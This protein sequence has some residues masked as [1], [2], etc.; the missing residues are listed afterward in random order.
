VTALLATASTAQAHRLDA[1]AFLLPGNKLQVEGWFSSGEPA[2]G[3][4]V[5]IHGAEDHLLCEGKL[6]DQ[7]IFVCTL[8][9]PESLHIVVTAGD[10][11]RKELYVSV[12]DGTVQASQP[13]TLADRNTSPPFRDILIGIAFL[14]ALAA[15]AMAYRNSRRIKELSEVLKTLPGAPRDT[16]DSAQR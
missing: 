12:P 4:W 11:H 7:G 10:E 5:R 13:L 2:R 9:Q 15:F 3:A 14:L 6:D 8:K 16:T 1:Q